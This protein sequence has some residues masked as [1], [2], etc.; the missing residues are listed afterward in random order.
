[1]RYFQAEDIAF[2][3][4]DGRTVSVKDFL[5]LVARAERSALVACGPSTAL[6]EV[7]S[8]VEVYGDDMEALA[9][10]IFDEN[11]VELTDAGYDI[12]KLKTLRVPL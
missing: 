6:D 3:D 8:R 11:I 9:Y 2:T 10:R 12:G 4:A 1:M 7:A 5:P